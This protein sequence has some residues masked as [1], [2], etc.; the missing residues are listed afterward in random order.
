MILKIEID[1]STNSLWIKNK[2]GDSIKKVY[3]NLESNPEFSKIFDTC[4]KLKHKIEKLN[5]GGVLLQQA[6]TTRQ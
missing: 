5:K 2:P 4:K 6:K 3:V 1:Y